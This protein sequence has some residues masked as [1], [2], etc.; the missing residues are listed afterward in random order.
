MKLRFGIDFNR[1]AP[2]NNIHNAEADILLIHGDKD[3]TIPLAQG[4]ALEKFGN[5]EK[6]ALVGCSR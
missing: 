2:V 3:V 1:I 5:I 4:Q 6:N